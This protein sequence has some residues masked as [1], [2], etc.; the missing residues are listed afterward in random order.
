[1]RMNPAK[2]MEIDKI[3]KKNFRIIGR[4][5]NPQIPAGINPIPQ[6]ADA[7]RKRFATAG[8]PSLIFKESNV[9]LFFFFFFFLVFDIKYGGVDG[10]GV[11]GWC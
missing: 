11:N 10:V 4:V 7:Y 3:T 5:A 8:L 9:I 1:M 6:S 2:M